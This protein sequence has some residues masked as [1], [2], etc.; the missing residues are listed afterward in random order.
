MRSET[1]TGGQMDTSSSS[2]MKDLQAIMADAEEL[3]RATADQAAPRVQEARAR[4]EET[5][6]A[7]RERLQGTGRELDAQV[8]ENPWVAVGVAAG[9]GLLIGVLLARK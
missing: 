7:A 6:R 8:R 4:A 5:L 2:W 3:L 9:I 1:S